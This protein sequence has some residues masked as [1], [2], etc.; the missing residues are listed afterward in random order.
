MSPS[1]CLSTYTW[2]SP[3]LISQAAM[4]NVPYIAGT[5]SPAGI[6]DP[7]IL[8]TGLPGANGP[9]VLLHIWSGSSEAIRR[10]TFLELGHIRLLAVRFHLV[11]FLLIVPPRYKK[12]SL[13][14]NC[15]AA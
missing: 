7:N 1:L 8:L 12:I 9:L 14:L 6:T 11:R 10:A 5:L 4:M 15:F 13:V 2:P 3:S